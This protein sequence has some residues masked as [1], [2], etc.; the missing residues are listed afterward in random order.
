M[1]VG[2]DASGANKTRKPL[3][4]RYSVMPSTLVDLTALA[5]PVLALPALRAAGCGA[6][7]AWSSGAGAAC[8]TVFKPWMRTSL[9][10]R[11][12][13]AGG[14]PALMWE[15]LQAGRLQGDCRTVTG[16]SVGGPAYGEFLSAI[17][18][19]W[20]RRDV[21]TVFVQ[22]FDAALASWYGAPPALKSEE[23]RVMVTPTWADN[24]QVYVRQSDPLPLT[25]VSMT[26]EVA[27]GS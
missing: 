21:G 16:R 22:T 5:P 12:F 26:L 1:V 9:G 20:V 6:S 17:F 10:E 4:S 27:I 3:G 14:V 18:D 13:R 24:G 7:A 11:F 8:Q 2:L 19:E 25:I 15:L 23:V